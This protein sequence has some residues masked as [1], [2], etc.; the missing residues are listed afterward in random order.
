MKKYTA[1]CNGEWMLSSEVSI[2]P[3]DR[4]I[5]LGDS[6]YD[7]VRTF[8]GKCFRLDAHIDRLYRSLNSVSID[9]GLSP[10]EM[11]SLVEECVKKNENLRSEVGDHRIWIYVSRGP[12]QW[13]HDAGPST[14]VIL[15]SP[16]DYGRYARFYK[17]GA[18]GIIPKIHSYAVD[19]LDPRI[20]HTSR[21]NFN[22][23]EI[24]VAKIDPEAWPMLTDSDGYL[25]EGT[26]YNIF[27][28]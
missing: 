6:I 26:A 19:T 14:V 17:T 15:V 18:H 13:A 1:Y 20:K 7:A 11:T 22:L 8:N 2:S 9:P 5:T 25:T 23:A 21:M 24:E 12:G 16:L 28:V 10:N 3:D 4:G 27:I